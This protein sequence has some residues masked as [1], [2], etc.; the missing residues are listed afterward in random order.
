MIAVNRQRVFSEHCSHISPSF[1]CVCS[2]FYEILF[3]WLKS[4][5]NM[6]TCSFIYWTN[7]LVPFSHHTRV[8]M[9]T[10]SFFILSTHS[11]ELCLVVACMVW[12]FSVVSYANFLLRPSYHTWNNDDQIP[13]NLSLSLS[14][15]CNL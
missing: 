12:H 3:S 9:N 11:F 7:W 15:S 5:R 10:N 13:T 6:F 2:V 14:I 8:R 1:F 4:T